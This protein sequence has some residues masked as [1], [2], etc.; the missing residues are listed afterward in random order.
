MKHLSVGI[1]C[2]FL[3]A[4]ALA[5]PTFLNGG[6]ET[7][8]SSSCNYNISNATFNSL[9]ANTVAYGMDQELDIMDFCFYGT[10][11]SGNWL[12][13]LAN[14]DGA[15]GTGDAFTMQLSAPLVAGTSYTLS[16]WDRGFNVSGCCP[17]GGRLQIGLSTVAG[18]TGTVIYTSPFP[19]TN[20]WNNRVF[21]FSA[22][23]NGQFISVMILDTRW[24]HVDDFTFV[25][26][27]EDEGLLQFSATQVESHVAIR[28][29]PE[30]TTGVQT[31]FVERMDTEGYFQPIGH[32]TPDQS[33]TG[34]N[35]YEFADSDP[36]PGENRYRIRTV[37]EA[38]NESYTEVKTVHFAP[39]GLDL[40]NFSW[41]G[42]DWNGRIGIVTPQLIHLT[43]M[44]IQ[45][46]KVWSGEQSAS[47]G[48]VEISVPGEG[49]AG[50]MYT[51]LVE[52]GALG[53][54]TI[55]LMHP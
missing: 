44:D 1:T 17:P 54:R 11:H 20:V 2:L 6:F 33:I 52:A 4:S 39:T 48:F 24:T 18:A 55:K 21:T 7:N 37:L 8:T 34:T 3:M 16:Y 46:R 5:Q 26:P 19:T 45:G 38:G 49:L 41:N 50:G 9:M 28:F 42:K 12:V 13:S 32:F 29:N 43:L 47:E 15:A 14:G 27:L 36:I 35:G 51:L 31:W 40:S 53:R 22:P 23:N 10:P 25:V 30:R